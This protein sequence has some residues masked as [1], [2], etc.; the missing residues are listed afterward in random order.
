M[1]QNEAGFNRRQFIGSVAAAGTV[2]MACG[3]PTPSAKIPEFAD[4]APDGKELKAGL[5]GC[6]GRGTGAAMDF[7]NSANGLQIVALADVFQDRIDGCRKSLKENKKVEIA[8][9]KCFVGLDAYKDLLA[10]DV[11]VILT[12]TPPY[13]R[14]I[15]FA[16]AVEA[17]KHVFMEKP[18]A[19][20]PVGA[21]TI[22]QSAE[23]AKAFG[24]SVVTGTQRRHQRNYNATFAQIKAGAI[25]EIRSANIYW[26]QSQLW[27]L[28][29]KP[30]WSDLEWSIRNWVNWAWLSGD[31]IVE[32]HVHNIDVVHWFTGMLPKS[33]VGFGSRQRRVTGDQYDN[34]SIDYVYENDMHVHSMCRQINSCTNNVSEFIMGSKGYT[35]CADKI[36]NSKGELI[37]EYPYPKNE[38]GEKIEELSPYVQEHVDLVTAIRTDQPFNEAAA[39]AQSTLV[40][41]MGRMSAYTGKQQDWNTVVESAFKLGPEKLNFG[42]FKMKEDIPV[43]G[44]ESKTR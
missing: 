19:V 5:I 3:G 43:P 4:K 9:D 22:I 32:Q 16:A 35:N 42:S 34:F 11:D 7:L 23:K 24:L 44:T 2:L 10:T 31:H 18:V 40:A 36:W 38:S 20:D 13:F 33:C 26:N 1:K 29:K 39:T 6:G 27:A 21:R 15:H 41:I 37:W 17:K 8:D 12:A 14:P 28:K 30:G 25:G